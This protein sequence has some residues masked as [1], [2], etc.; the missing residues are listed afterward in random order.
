MFRFAPG[1]TT[2]DSAQDLHHRRAHLTR[3]GDHALALAAAAADVLEA[4]A[5]GPVVASRS[6]SQL[7]ARLGR[8]SS[9]VTSSTRFCVAGLQQRLGVVLERLFSAFS[10]ER[11]PVLLRPAFCRPAWSLAL[12]EQRERDG[13]C[14]R[15]ASPTCR[16]LRAS[17][18]ASSFAP[19]LS[20]YVRR[21]AH[22]PEAGSL[23][24]RDELGVLGHEA[25]AG[26]DV[27]VAVSLGD[28]DDLADALRLLFLARPM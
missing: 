13:R 3:L 1:A 11:Q 7:I 20:R 15:P 5:A 6:R 18:L 28:L 8:S 12:R 21:R 17:F 10:C 26:E 25:V 22:E 2:L 19:A 4:D 14:R 24:R 9:I 16:A 23:D 27:R